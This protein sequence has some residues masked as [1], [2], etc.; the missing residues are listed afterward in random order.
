MLRDLTKMGQAALARRK[1]RSHVWQARY[2]EIAISKGFGVVNG[3]VASGQLAVDLAQFYGSYLGG[4]GLNIDEPLKAWPT[5]MV[6]LRSGIPF[7]P[8]KHLLMQAFLHHCDD[9]AKERTCRPP[10]RQPVDSGIRDAATARTLMKAARSANR[11]KARLTLP[12]LFNGTAAWSAF[13]HGRHRFPLTAEVV[14]SFRASEASQR[15]A[16]GR[17]SW[18]RRAQIAN[19]TGAK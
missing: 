1:H 11:R 4:L 7:A 14:S 5:A 9:K 17:D 3:Q 16:G 8:L 12:Q 18:R 19:A 13:R 10:G 6:R 15:K 2:R